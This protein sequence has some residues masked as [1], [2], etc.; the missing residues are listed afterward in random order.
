[1]FAFRLGSSAD[2]VLEFRAWGVKLSVLLSEINAKPV[3]KNGL[4]AAKLL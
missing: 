1:M 4:C 2:F 3:N